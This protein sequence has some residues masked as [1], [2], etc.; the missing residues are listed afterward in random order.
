MHTVELWFL[1]LLKKTMD[2]YAYPMKSTMKQWKTIHVLKGKHGYSSAI[3]AASSICPM[4]FSEF[5][6]VNTILEAKH[7][8]N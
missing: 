5:F 3:V 8:K 7:T 2:T 1:T 4:N 6:A